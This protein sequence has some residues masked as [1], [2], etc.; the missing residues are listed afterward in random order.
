MGRAVVVGADGVAGRAR[1]EAPARDLAGRAPV[2]L[3]AARA[4]L[5]VA[6]AA[7]AGGMGRVAVGAVA[8]GRMRPRSGRVSASSPS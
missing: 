5:A 7:V 3:G 4:A 8:G 6:T 2:A 1:V